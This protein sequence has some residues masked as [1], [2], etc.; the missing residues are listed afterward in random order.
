MWNHRMIKTTTTTNFWEYH[1]SLLAP[2]TPEKQVYIS[3]LVTQKKE[4]SNNVEHI[5]K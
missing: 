4:K 1:D 2:T 5:E 3:L